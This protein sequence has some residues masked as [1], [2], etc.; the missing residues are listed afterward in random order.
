MFTSPL[1]IR[2]LRRSSRH[3]GRARRRGCL[4]AARPHP[5]FRTERRGS[6]ASNAPLV[7]RAL[8]YMI[9]ELVCQRETEAARRASRRNEI[10]SCKLCLLTAVERESR[11]LGLLGS[12]NTSTVHLVEPLRLDS[13]CT[14]HRFCT[15]NIPGGTF[16]S[17]RSDRPLDRERAFNRERPP[18]P[19]WV[20][21]VPLR[22]RRAG[23]G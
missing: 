21:P 5:Q 11:L 12:R 10:D 22:R 13:N 2:F 15:L 9:G 8:G 3:D 23:S 6:A 7:V 4:Q 16:S 14:R 17:S 20:S 18:S 19:R 1:W